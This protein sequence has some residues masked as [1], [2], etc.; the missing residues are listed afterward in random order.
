MY[1]LEKN[2]KKINELK[3]ENYKLKEIN[4]NL[5]TTGHSLYR[6]NYDEFLKID[7]EIKKNK[8][9]IELNKL[10]IAILKNNLHFLLRFSFECIKSEIIEHYEKR[11]IGEKTKEKIINNIKK[12]F[13]DN[14]NVN[15]GGYVTIETGYYNNYYDMKITLY[16]LNEEGRKDFTL[17]YNEE[18]TINFTTKDDKTEVYYYNTITEY[19]ELEDLNK[20]AGDLMKEYNKT[21]N[22][23]EK[24][25]LQQKELYHNFKDYLQAFVCNQL[26]I[27]TTLRIY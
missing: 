20:K 26:E 11:K 7:N 23:I 2:I 15:I 13:F 14:F 10:K 6:S 19:V 16:F 18:F 1:K 25:R 5:V 24:M 22:K 4:N 27:E 9:K 3:K 17:E 12:F 8:K 21:K